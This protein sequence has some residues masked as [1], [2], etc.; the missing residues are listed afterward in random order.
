MKRWFAALWL[1]SFWPAAGAQEGLILQYRLDEGRGEVLTDASGGGRDAVL[2]GGTWVR[3]RQRAALRFDGQRTFGE[4]AGGEVGPLAEAFSV[5]LWFCPTMA[6]RSEP[7]ALAVKDG[8]FRLL[9]YPGQGKFLVHLP[10]PEGGQG[11]YE[12][13]EGPVE[14]GSWHHLALTY[15]RVGPATRLYLDG[16]CLFESDRDVGAV[17]LSNAPLRLGL[18]VNPEQQRFFGG[19]MG[20]FRLWNRALDGKEIQQLMAQEKRSL[21]GTFRG[22][23]DVSPR[24]PPAA[25]LDVGDRKQLFIDGRFI[26]DSKNVTLTMNPPRKVGPVILP[27]RPWESCSIGFCVSVVEHDGLFQMWY[28]AES[29]DAGAFV[30]YA[31]SEDGLH[32]TK[33]NLGLIEFQGSKENNIV[34]A[35]VGETVVFLD[36]SAPDAQRFKALAVRFW[37][38]PEKGGLYVHCSPDGLHWRVSDERVLPLVPD[39]ANQAAYDTRLG[40]YVAYIRVWNPMRKVGRVE[41]DDILQPWPYTPLAQPYYIWGEDKVPVTSREVPTV[42]GYDD[43]DPVPSDHYNAAAVEYPWAADAYFLFPSAYFHFPDPPMGKRWNDGLLDIQMAVSRD[44]IAWQRL[45]RR[46]YVPL[47]LEGEKDSKQLYM[48]VGMLRAGNEVFQYYGGYETTHGA[49]RP[50]PDEGPIGSICGLVQRLDGFVSADAAFTG[51]QLLTPPLVWA[52]DH[53]ELNV[54]TSALGEARVGLLDA[55]GEPLPGYEVHR[56]DPLRG[57]FIAQ[58]VTWQ[59]QSDLTPLAGRPVRL[60]FVLRSAKLYAFQFLSEG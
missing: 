44:G 38:D 60:H 24:L 3:N 33:P 25:P 26:E 39:T 13:V 28:R 20:G 5:D 16:V 29:Q 27:D 57:N 30:C 35:D 2:H 49:P 18:G 32:W 46:P 4:W 22:P 21:E 8:T 11:V 6:P 53:L 48:A 14:E 55:E 40:K 37:P 1:L 56:C 36:P 43:Q 17:G 31:T 50:T 15:T 42:F 9:F 12:T 51:G 58:T 54:D 19:L 23:D 47:G 59:G 10:G 41:M 45:D 52:G 34:L 7:A